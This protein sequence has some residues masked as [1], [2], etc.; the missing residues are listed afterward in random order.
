MVVR[1]GEVVNGWVK[2]GVRGVMG[3]VGELKGHV[4][5]EMAEEVAYWTQDSG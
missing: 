3:L 4:D 2:R 1:G 5:G